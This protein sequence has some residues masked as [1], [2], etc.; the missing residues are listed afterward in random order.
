MPS[1][2][3][4]PYPNM[5]PRTEGKEL[6][7][8]P[9][10]LQTNPGG[11]PAH[12]NPMSQPYP[13]PFTPMFNSSST[14]PPRAPE[15][16]QKLDERFAKLEKLLAEQKAE[17]AAKQ[18]EIAKREAEMARR[19]SEEMIAKAVARIERVTAMSSLPKLGS[20]KNLENGGTNGAR[21][22]IFF[23]DAVGRKFTFPFERCKTWSVG[24]KTWRCSK[25]RPIWLPR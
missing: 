17:G 5:Q 21:E 18:A 14:A 8:N 1:H 4:I 15:D 20:E 12:T 7:L 22:V 24:E 23:K 16:N 3:I 10:N 6:H 19:A 25:K 9:P 11:H 2:G 13:P